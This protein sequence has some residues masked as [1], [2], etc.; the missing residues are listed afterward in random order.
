[1]IQIDRYRQREA[2]RVEIVRWCRESSWKREKGFEKGD[3]E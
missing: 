1:M 3:R 2:R